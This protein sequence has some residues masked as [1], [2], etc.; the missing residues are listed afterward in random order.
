MTRTAVV[1]ARQRV[2]EAVTD[3]ELILRL[4]GGLWDDQQVRLDTLRDVSNWMADEEL[5]K[6]TTPEVASEDPNRDTKALFES[7]KRKLKDERIGR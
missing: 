1:T 6:A 7:Y 5:D 4:K 2:A 3:L